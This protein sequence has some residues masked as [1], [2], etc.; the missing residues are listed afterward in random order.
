MKQVQVVLTTSIMANVSGS[1]VIDIFTKRRGI[2]H[3]FQ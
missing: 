1:G 2:I 3:V